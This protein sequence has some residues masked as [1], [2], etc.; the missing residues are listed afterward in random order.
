MIL[1]AGVE[2]SRDTGTAPSVGAVKSILSRSVPAPWPSPRASC[3]ALT[4]GPDARAERVTPSAR[5]RAPGAERR[6]RALAPDL[7]P[8]PSAGT[9]PVRTRLRRPL[10]TPHG[11]R[12]QRCPRARRTPPR[13]LSIHSGSAKSRCHAAWRRVGEGI[14]APPEGAAQR[15][16]RPC[17]T[18]I[19]ASPSRRHCQPARYPLR[20][21][22][23]GRRRVRIPSRRPYQAWAAFTPTAWRSSSTGSCSRRR[24]R[25]SSMSASTSLSAPRSRSSATSARAIRRLAPIVR[26]DSDW[27]S[28]RVNEGEEPRDPRAR[29]SRASWSA[30]TE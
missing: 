6:T 24:R 9:L 30:E 22:H 1:T 12:R 4:P 17:R 3:R 23:P 21:P 2:G 28:A 5:S 19:R 26:D 16:A 18:R 7:A 14:T 15:R 27:R 25:R 11:R 13:Q 10:D 8:S 29:R 20:P